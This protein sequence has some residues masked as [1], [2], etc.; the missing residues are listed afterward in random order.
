MSVKVR[1]GSRWVESTPKRWDGSRWVT[2]G[3]LKRYDGSRWVTIW[4][5][6]TVPNAPGAPELGASNNQIAVSWTAPGTGGSP[7]THYDLRYR[8]SG[9]WTQI[10]T[11]TG[12]SRTISSLTNGSTYEVQVRAAN[13]RGDGAWSSTATAVPGA[14]PGKPARPTLVASNNQIVVSW[15]A[16]SSA[17]GPITSYSVRYRR[18]TGAATRIDNLSGTSHTL[19]SLDNGHSYEIRV[20]AANAKGAGPWSDPVTATPGAIPSKP[21]APSLAT[22]NAQI[23]ASWSAPSS[24]AGALTHY[25]LRHRRVG[26]SS[27]TQVDGITSRSRTVTGLSNG[28]SY[29]FQVRAANAIG[30]GAWSDSMTATPATVPSAPNAPSLATGNAQ[31]MVSWSA[32][33]A[34]GAS[35]THYDLQHR[36]SGSWTLV[37]NIS[38][39]SRTIT[40][41]TNGTAYQV[42]VRAANSAGDGS[43]SAT[44]TATPGATPNAPSAPS[45][46]SSSGQITA[47]WTAPGNN[48]AAIT[49]YD[50]RYREGGSGS[51]TTVEESSR[52]R[53]ITG[54]TNGRSYEFQVRAANSRGDGAWSSTATAVPGAVPGKPSAPSLIPSNGQ[55]MV[56]WSAPSST[57]GAIT[58]Y[59]LQYRRSGSWTQ[60]DGITSRSRTIT[61][62][63]NGSSYE[64]RVRAANAVGDGAW[65]NT[66]SATPTN[67]SY[68]ATGAYSTHTVGGHVHIVW[69]S[70]GSISFTGSY[71]VQFICIAGGGGG[72]GSFRWDS[73]N[74]NPRPHGGGGGGGAGGVLL[75]SS[76]SISGKSVTITVGA[77][78]TRSEGQ[79]GGFPDRAQQ[80]GNSSAAIASGSTFT[81]IGGGGGGRSDGGDGGSG[82]GGANDGDGGSGTSGQGNDGGDSD[83]YTVS[84]AQA[85]RYT[86][87]GGG[88]GG[89][90]AGGDGSASSS[91]SITG[92]A[93]GAGK[94]LNLTGSNVTY[95]P[96]GRGGGDGNQTTVDVPG[97]GGPGGALL[98]NSNFAARN[99]RSGKNGIVVARF[100]SNGG[101][102][103]TLS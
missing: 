95:A 66:T 79:I 82:G 1:S 64:V 73:F 52:S 15:T 47:S 56:S 101:S 71:N 97:A 70:N 16:P 76:Q 43:W 58:H 54:L 99:G 34:N 39:T 31:I 20:R 17:G 85:S 38:G 6:S 53:T 87:G 102:I 14:V 60:V 2:P 11:I 26:T 35:I 8:I 100:K 84:Q 89:G 9:S 24:N 50:L 28:R 74:R 22:G 67:R 7:I 96:G 32:P 36:I 81:A 55:I 91:T 29:E 41:L 12:T 42:R 49:H 27:W 46:T 45:L 44:A 88:G 23:T 21:N 10:D 68:T 65:S 92:G 18:G 4:E 69:S 90:G 63:T 33:N 51:W 83:G 75:S 40:G 59:D 80:G 98:N 30:D 72:Q 61:G 48:G 25:D 77:G 78:G 62:L 93:A 5:A 86:G 19:D 103:T 37:E 3:S 94:R 57:G 13:S